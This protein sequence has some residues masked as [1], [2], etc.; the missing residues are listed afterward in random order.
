MHSWDWQVPRLAHNCTVAVCCKQCWH[1]PP[2]VRSMRLR[3]GG[4]P[5]SKWRPPSS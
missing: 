3:P 4:Q 1:S 5:T 2:R